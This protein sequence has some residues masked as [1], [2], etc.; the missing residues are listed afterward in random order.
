MDWIRRKLRQWLGV[1]KNTQ[2][3]KCL[4]E[5][6]GN[7][8]NIGVDVHFKEPHMILI[9]SRLNGGQL[10]HIEADFKDL[11]QLDEL[12]R[13]L[14][15]RYRTDRETWDPPQGGMKLTDIRGW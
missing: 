10:R 7:L 6:Y 2:D 15:A 11:R 4:S 13:E 12:V 1:E 9:Y 5:L 14:K 8:V 3:I